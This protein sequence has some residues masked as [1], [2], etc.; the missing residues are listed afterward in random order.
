MQRKLLPLFAAVAVFGALMIPGLVQGATKLKGQMTGDQV[1]NP[2]GGAPDG[3]GR[4]KLRVNRVKRRI[5]F[6]IR[7]T[8]IGTTATESVLHKGKRNRIGRPIVTLFE[9]TEASPVE[10]CVRDVRRRFIKRL[11]RKPQRHY[12]DVDNSEYPDGAIRGQLRRKRG[13]GGGG[14]GGG[15]N[16]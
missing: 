7:Y 1:V 15:D 11:K 8:G 3:E 16:L 9:G 13:G 5:C 14:G 6:R 12:V 2:E 4:V 10:G